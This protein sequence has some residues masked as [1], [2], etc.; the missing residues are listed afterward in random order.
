MSEVQTDTFKVEL[1]AAVIPLPELALAD[2]GFKAVVL[3]RFAGIAH[4]ALGFVPEWVRWEEGPFTLLDPPELSRWERLLVF[5]RIREA[6]RPIRLRTVRAT[7][8]VYHDGA[9]WCEVE[10]RI[11]ESV[12]IPRLDR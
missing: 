9:M 11:P 4:E 6:P 5:L 7:V 3:D 8:F 12:R 10:R 1:W 2:L